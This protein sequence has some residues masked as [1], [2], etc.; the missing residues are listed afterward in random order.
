MFVTKDYE[1][2]TEKWV[3]KAKVTSFLG[4]KFITLLNKEKT[5]IISCAH[6][7][8]QHLHVPSSS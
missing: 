5:A 8:A 2:K 1:K 4:G 3:N 7:T 6:V